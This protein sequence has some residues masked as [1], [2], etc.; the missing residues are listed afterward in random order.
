MA[1]VG[2]LVVNLGLDR[3]G[4]SSGLQAARSDLASFAGGAL[5]YLG[6]LTGALAAAFGGKAI[7][8]ASRES[9]AA[10]KKLNATLAATGN[11]AGLSASEIQ[12]FATDLQQVTNFEDDATAAAAGVLATFK[13]IKGDTF[14]QAI[15][16]AQDLSAVMGQDLQSSI[17]QIGKALNDPIKGVTALQRV[18]VSFT[19]EQKKQIQQ[20]QKSGNL[21]GAQAIVLKELQSEFGGAAK[22]MAD[23]LIQVENAIGD[24]AENLGF[25]ILPAVSAIAQELM[26]WLGPVVGAGDGFKAAGQYVGDLVRSGVAGIK[27]FLARWGDTIL[28]VGKFVAIGGT[29]VGAVMALASAASFAGPA[30]GAAITLATGPFGLIVA[31]IAAAGA[32]IVQLTGEG[33]TF[34][35][36]LNDTFGK[37]PALIDGIGFAF[38][39][40][41]NVSQIAL[42]DANLAI[43]DLVPGAE[44]VFQTLGTY[45]VA[46]WDGVSAAGSAFVNNILGGFTE[47]KNVGMAVGAAIKAAFDALIS[48]ENPLEAFTAAFTK[49]LASSTNSRTF[50][51]PIEA[52]QKAFNETKVNAQVGFEDSGGL[53]K[54]LEADRARLEQNI[55]GDEAARAAAAA[56]AVQPAVTPPK[57]PTDEAPKTG[58]GKADKGPEALQA[59]TK[60]AF[61]SILGAIRGGK[62]P[63]AKV[64][65]NTGDMVREQRETNKQ[66][67][68]VVRAS[69]DDDAPIVDW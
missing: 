26:S 37:I 14:K 49:S 4:L 68:E 50:Q 2:D 22:A 11:A 38:R 69:E 67:R 66:L 55:V 60:E 51:N 34:G 5:K 24:V 27:E 13:E 32:A 17:V 29:A 7:L 10:E 65:Q 25:L 12:Q 54:M 20:L 15:V 42:I 59:G 33:E 35:A 45:L 28:A 30:I 56:K 63:N 61:S 41:A 47:I 31:A 48:G 18:G 8:D 6:P 1:T 9:I 57:P 64:E 53:K 39:N 40:M 58:T 16:S 23:P 43:Y 19:E 21:A 44:S 46:F 3:S 62:N 36:K 52:F